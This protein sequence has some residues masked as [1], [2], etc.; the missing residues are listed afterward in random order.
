MLRPKLSRSDAYC[1]LSVAAD[2]RVT[3]IVNF[4][5][6]GAH[7]VVEKELLAGLGEDIPPPVP[8]PLVCGKCATL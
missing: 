6:R 5:T 1:F 4:P 3:Q 7:V 8:E 2:V